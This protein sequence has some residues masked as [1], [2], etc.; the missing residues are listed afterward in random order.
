[1][2]TTRKQPE[3]ADGNDEKCSEGRAAHLQPRVVFASFLRRFA[4]ICQQ[5]RR[6]AGRQR[7][8]HGIDEVRAAGGVRAAL[9]LTP[10]LRAC[11]RRNAVVD[12]VKVLNQH[13]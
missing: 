1:M 2:G 4:S 5:L 13:L 3:A 8:H 11:Q 10:L 9:R 6:S 7:R 12:V